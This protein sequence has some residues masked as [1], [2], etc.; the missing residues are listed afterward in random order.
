MVKG[1]LIESKFLFEGADMTV[2]GIDDADWVIV[3]AGGSGFYR[4]TYDKTLTQK[5]TANPGV[6]STIEI[7]RAHV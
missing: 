7:G 4:V 2:D 1:K 3:N 5:L 6:L